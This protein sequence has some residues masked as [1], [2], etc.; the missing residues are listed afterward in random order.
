MDERTELAVEKA[1]LCKLLMSSLYR[2][3]C[4][5]ADADEIGKSQAYGY[6]TVSSAYNIGNKVSLLR[7]DFG[8]QESGVVGTIHSLV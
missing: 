1:E 4:E 5:R 3:V 6:T 2:D 8:T 7:K